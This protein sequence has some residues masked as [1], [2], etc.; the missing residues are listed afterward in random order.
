MQNLTDLEIIESVLLGNTGDYHLLINRY[1]H[2]AFSLLR[3][4]L[5][6]ELDAEDALQDSFVKAYFNL[7]AF[8]KEARFSTWFY[9]IVYN[10]ALNK[11]ASKSRKAED[12]TESLTGMEEEIP[13]HAELPM[14][15]EKSELLG[16]LLEYLTPNYV[17]VLNLFY[18]DGM[19]CEEIAE[20]MTLST[21]NVKV[22]LHRARTQL[23]KIIES[24]NLKEELL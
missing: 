22:L 6:N 21:G 15:S 8:R 11:L 10:T 13:A 9:R 7:K 17:T 3:R 24:N 14:G 5:G 4:M 19:S 16:S 1:K 20:I 18:F 2:R 12:S 23:K